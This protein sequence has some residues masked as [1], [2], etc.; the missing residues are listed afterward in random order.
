[1]NFIYYNERAMEGTVNSDS[2][3]NIRDGIKSIANQ[4]V[5]SNTEWSDA[6]SNWKKKPTTKCYSDALKNKA[7]LY[8]SVPVDI[9]SIKTVMAQGYPIVFGFT[10][11]ESFESDIVTRTG[12]VPMPKKSESALG[13]HCVDGADFDDSK[14]ACLCR[15]S[16]GAAWG[17]NGNFWLPYDYF[18]SNLVSDIWVVTNIL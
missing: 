9:N 16:W 14:R 17:L 5:C 10:V 8:R 18:T 15:N 12:I 13:G 11:Y 4:G 2:G 6:V 1:M 3:A 7:V